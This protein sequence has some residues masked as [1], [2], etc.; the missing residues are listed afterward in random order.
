MQRLPASREIERFAGNG[1]ECHRHDG[2]RTLGGVLYVGD[3]KRRVENAVCA[4]DGRFV[5]GR[6][7]R[8]AEAERQQ[9]GRG[10]P[11]A[12][13]RHGVG[14]VSYLSIRNTWFGGTVPAEIQYWD[15]AVRRAVF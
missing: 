12:D 4:P 10:R 13:Q 7:C 5:Q 6:A 14:H 2:D 1:V 15:Q 8:Q 11:A 9:E 3:V